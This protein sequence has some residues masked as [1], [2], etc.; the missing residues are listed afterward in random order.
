MRVRFYLNC[1]FPSVHPPEYI[2]STIYLSL[3][4]VSQYLFVSI[5]V[6]YNENISVCVE[7][8]RDCRGR[9]L[10]FGSQIFTI[11]T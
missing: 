5:I 3:L 7:E 4:S 9:G 10:K 1:F 6:H 2:I 11:N 8:G